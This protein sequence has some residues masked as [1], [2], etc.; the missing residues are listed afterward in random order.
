MLRPLEQNMVVFFLLLNLEKLFNNSQ[1]HFTKN[2]SPRWENLIMAGKDPPILLL[3]AAALSW[4]TI[5][6]FSHIFQ[7]TLSFISKTN[8]TQVT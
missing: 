1:I 4:C 3:F 6:Q 7:F 8:P 5:Q 2:F